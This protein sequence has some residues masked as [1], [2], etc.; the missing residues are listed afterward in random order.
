MR[1]KHISAELAKNIN[2][3]CD[4]ND[5]TAQTFNC[6]TNLGLKVCCAHFQLF[7]AEI[8]NA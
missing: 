8:A 7:I 6:N 2:R 4:C 3:N 5:I 1:N